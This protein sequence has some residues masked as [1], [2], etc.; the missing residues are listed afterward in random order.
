M[1]F[2]KVILVF[3]LL[4]EFALSLTRKNKNLNQKRKGFKLKDNCEANSFGKGVLKV[5]N[6]MANLATGK[7]D[8]CDAELECAYGVAQNEEANS[9]PYKAC[10][11]KVGGVDDWC[12]ENTCN[13]LKN[14]VCEKLENGR[15]DS[16][17]KAIYRFCKKIENQ[18]VKNIN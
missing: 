18:T 11:K 5:F 9:V 10:V 1:K 3:V 12:A 13:K 16:E 2:V 4:C 17:K 8:S 14:L 6:S 7:M 15:L